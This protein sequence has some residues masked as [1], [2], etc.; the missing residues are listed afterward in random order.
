MSQQLSVTN[1]AV[2]HV[3]WPVGRLCQELKIATHPLHRYEAAEL[4][5]EPGCSKVFRTQWVGKIVEDVVIPE[6][7]LL[8]SDVMSTQQGT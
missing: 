5:F 3:A 6:V 8:P 7:S 1:N 4:L 2:K